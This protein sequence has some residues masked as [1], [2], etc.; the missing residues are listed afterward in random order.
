MLL[1]VSCSDD[2][3][4]TSPTNQIS[5]E[6][7]FTTALGAQTVIDGTLRYM[8]EFI[9]N[10]DQFGVK[11]ID[12]AQD[13]MGEDIAP[14]RHHWFGFDYRIDNRNATYRR[15]TYAWRLYYRII[16]NMN[17][18]IN[19]IDEASAENEDLKENLKAQALTLRGYAYFQ[20]IQLFQFT[21]VGHENDPGVPIYLEATTEGQPR[22]SVSAVYSQIVSDLDQAITLFGNSDIPQRHISDPTGNVAKGLRARVALVMNNW[23]KAEQMAAEAR[24]G[25]Q[26]MD[27][28]EFQAGFDSYQ[29]QNWMWGLEIN[30]EQ[31]TIYA[32]WFSHM[33]MT[34]G[35]YA[36]LGYS[37]KQVGL[38][39]YQ[40]MD[41]TDI[42]YQLI[43]PAANGRLVNYKFA[44]A[45]DKEFAAD[46]VLMRPEE[47]LLIE[48]EA[49]ARQGETDG[50]QQLLEELYAVRYE[51]PVEVTASGDA[52]LQK[53]LLERRIELWGEGFRGYDI[54]RLKIGIDR[55]GSN[56]DPVVAANKLTVAPEDKY[57]IYQIPQAEIDAND[58]I[59]EA[60]Q[61][62]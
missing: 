16:Y 32:S 2:Y 41:T 54:K 47:M 42:R 31:S 33:D 5:D 34:I 8:R 12:L 9:D 60:D 46:Y 55:T 57:M 24:E 15:P 38:K 50:A 3:L 48:A 44:A 14:T 29:Q 26:L 61:N 28:D 7:V 43:V 39:L 1:A 45:G 6:A 20:L 4:E 40:Q 27:Q 19:N 18:V 53:I 23:E 51:A 25:Y 62:P 52:L 13:L 35:G 56:H 10:H 49:K 21:Y 22:E 11:A 36:G 37:P 17:G 59:T 30:D 58:N